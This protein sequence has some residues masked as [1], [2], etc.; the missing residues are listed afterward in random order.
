MKPNFNYWK[1]LWY[2]LTR[3]MA[4]IVQYITANGENL[5][6]EEKATTQ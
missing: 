6:K 1:I 3:K 5:A 2:E 4:F